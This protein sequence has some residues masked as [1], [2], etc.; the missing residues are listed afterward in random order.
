MCRCRV[1]GS[2]TPIVTRSRAVE[3]SRTSA[4][5]CTFA[6]LL[7]ASRERVRYSRSRVE[8]LAP[9]GLGQGRWRQPCPFSDA[10]LLWFRLWLGYRPDERDEPSNEKTHQ[11]AEDHLADL[12]EAM[13]HATDL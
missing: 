9:C 5:T 11:A 2:G 3:P 4:T 8:A 12:M 10:A 13:L 1:F 7:R 6:L